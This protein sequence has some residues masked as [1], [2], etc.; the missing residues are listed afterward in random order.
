MGGRIAPLLPLLLQLVIFCT[1]PDIALALLA[2]F[3][4]LAGGDGAA[5]EVSPPRT[6]GGGSSPASSFA[7]GA[8]APPR[9]GVT[10]PPVPPAAEMFQPGAGPAKRVY[11]CTNRWCKDAGSGATLGSFIGLASEE[12]VLVQGVNCLGRCNKG[13]NLR[14]RMEDMSW[15]EFNRIDSVDRVHRILRDYLKVPVKNSAA[16]CLKYNFEGNAHL[17][18]NDV[19]KAIECYDKAIATG[20]ADQE[21]VLLV[22]RAT[23]YLQ[24][25]YAH[26][27]ALASV[28]G[29]VAR[30][31]PS[32]DM[33]MKTH[34][35]TQSHPRIAYLL[36]DRLA[37]Y[38]AE[39]EN[40][41]ETAKFRYGLYEFALLRAC[42]DALRATQLL[43]NYAK[44]WLRA[45]DALA[46][47][48]KL[49]EAADHYE[50]AVSLDPSLTETLTTIERF[51]SGM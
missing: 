3:R 29:K 42:D 35:I 21:G 24:R 7:G 39:K 33:L 13:P 5:G 44:C 47:L 31:M 36:V 4:A 49:Q 11:V 40:L 15:L 34:G 12:E 38:C 23:A 17:D 19:S 16:E 6:R 18:S 8:A 20:W 22:M 32:L 50:V 25:A 14:V 10:A 9:I 1:A 46:E 26:R 27:R 51:R 28:L 45:G 37:R 41:Y 2:N 30:G 43:P 48:R